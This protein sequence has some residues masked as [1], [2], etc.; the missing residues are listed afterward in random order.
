MG[1]QTGGCAR[2]QHVQEHRRED[3]LGTLQSLMLLQESHAAPSPAQHTCDLAYDSSGSRSRLAHPWLPPAVPRLAIATGGRDAPSAGAEE[4]P[5]TLVPAALQGRGQG[6]WGGRRAPLG[7]GLRGAPVLVSRWWAGLH[8]ERHQQQG[9]A[10]PA[11]APH[12]SSGGSTCQR[13]HSR[14]GARSR[15]GAC[16]RLSHAPLPQ[17]PRRR[18]L[19]PPL[20]GH[21]PGRAR[22]CVAPSSQ[23]RWCR[24]R[25]RRR[26]RRPGCPAHG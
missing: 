25:H 20:P 11:A 8:S 21:Q 9:Q 7:G 14:T 1:D 23:L 12:S 5:D 15:S 26:R 18:P 19:L 22:A 16:W 10:S 17:Q 2:A 6:Q 4:P 24:H 3:T 13:S